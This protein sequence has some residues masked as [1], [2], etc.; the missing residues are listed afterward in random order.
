M[1]IVGNSDLAVNLTH[2]LDSVHLSAI[3]APGALDNF[4]EHFTNE[5]EL[6][7]VVFIDN[8]AD[9]HDFDVTPDE[10]IV[11][12]KRAAEIVTDRCK[13]HNHTNLHFEVVHFH[14]LSTPI[15]FPT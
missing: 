7:K 10:I 8:R 3:T 13:G 1:I 14:P 5:S 12:L 15:Y 6:V 2:R 9:P 11:S 4:R